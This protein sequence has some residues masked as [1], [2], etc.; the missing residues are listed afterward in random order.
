MSRIPK[1]ALLGSVVLAANAY[2]AG[3][4]PA[5]VFKSAKISADVTL[6]RG[7]G[8]YT[9]A[10]TVSNAAGNTGEIAQFKIDVSADASTNGM[11]SK[12]SG[13]TLPLGSR[14][15]D[16]SNMLARFVKLNASISTPTR[17]RTETI[18]PF[19]QA[20]PPGWNGGMGMDSIASFSVKGGGP[21]ILPGSSL[22]GFQLL[23]FGVPTIRDTQ[24]IPLW[25]HV[26]EDHDAVAEADMKAAGRI[27]RDIIFHTVTLG[28]SGVSYGS[29]AHWN[30]LRDDLAR[31][32]Q[33]R[34]IIDT[35]LAKNLTDQLASARRALD[36]RD[37]SAART[38]LQT[39]LAT[40][41]RSTP[42]QTTR[43]G[44]ALVS[45]NVQSMLDNARGD[46]SPEPK[47]TLSPKSAVLS[48]GGRQNLS[49]NLIDLADA[50]RP[51]AG[52][53][54]TF[55]VD[56]GPNAGKLGDAQTD[57]QGNAAISYVGRKPGTDK[58]SARGRLPGRE[59]GFDD[60][61]LVLWSGGADLTIFFFIPPLLMT[62]G[63]RTF[64]VNE[65]TQNI[66]DAATP[67]S[68]T[69]YFIS[70]DPNFGPNATRPAGER[71]VPAL[72]PGE[73]SVIKQQAFTVPGD[74]PEGT[75]FL[76]ACADA[77]NAVVELDENNNCSS[78]KT[79][80]R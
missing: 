10:Y 8:R 40:I 48:V 9:Y 61:G 32:I 64:Y 76:A 44:S 1:I 22:G 73:S 31:A 42:G 49:V 17:L 34:W 58:V 55:H 39:L 29:I 52:I 16:F 72:Q 45:L 23:S 46:K 67:P 75:Y 60:T 24:I 38:Q 71:R 33:L 30:Q 78:A 74:L 7:T 63:G 20:V 37:L 35:G 51:I 50:S 41:N 36:A 68:V 6:D 56:S 77:E 21:G 4:L 18:V 80:G 14:Q 27:E 53:P 26:V 11:V 47:I 43:E 69:R 2:A 19:G 28:A 5:P 12:T 70:S 15:I 79:R 59:A 66:G 3:S 62:A 25:M 65:S 54:I 13:L 57:A